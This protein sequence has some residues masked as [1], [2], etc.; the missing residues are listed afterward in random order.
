MPPFTKRALYSA[1]QKRLQ[2]EARSAWRGSALGSVIEDVRK[3]SRQSAR[4]DGKL[5]SALEGLA[6]GGISGAIGKLGKDTSL[7]GLVQDVIR[8]SRTNQS[9]VNAF[10]K[11]LGPAGKI[12]SAIASAVGT[13]RQKPTTGDRDVDAARDLL[14]AFGYQV[15]PQAST[16]ATKASIEAAKA[17]LEQE[18]YKVTK[19]P[20]GVSVAPAPSGG[21]IAEPPDSGDDRDFWDRVA[22]GSQTRSRDDGMVEVNIGVGKQRFPKDH[23]IITKKK[24]PTPDSSNVYWFLYDIDTRTLYIRF[25][26]QKTKHNPSKRPGPVYSYANF[27]PQGFLDMIKASSKG[28]FVWD[29]IRIRGTVS[30]HRYSYN[31]ER[32]SENYV[33]RKATL[34]PSGEWYIQRKGVATTVAGK[35]TLV[36]SKPSVPVSHLPNRGTP[37]RGRPNRGR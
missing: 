32:I 28:G 22:D 29:R 3:N 20:K 16:G 14:E 6:R 2:R 35:R 36:K 19:T 26:A 33:P 24:V 34:T 21:G 8:Y 18:G 37:N 13:T 9:L 1:T 11:Q 12:I 31:L 30:G 27:P 23:P 4:I 15:S 7:N 5:Q 17:F 10:L 25:D